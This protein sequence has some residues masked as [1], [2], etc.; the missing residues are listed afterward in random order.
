[1]KG[2]RYPKS[3]FL[4]DCKALAE[5]EGFLAAVK[6]LRHPKGEFFSKP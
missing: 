4:A 1:V 6:A 5:K 3:E 2:L